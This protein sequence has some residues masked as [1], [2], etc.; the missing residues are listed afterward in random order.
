MGPKKSQKVPL[1]ELLQSNILISPSG[2]ACIADFGQATTK[3]SKPIVM[4]VNTTRGSSGTMKWQAP[5]LFP[6]LLDLD[7]DGIGQPNTQATDIYAFAMVCYEVRQI[8]IG[9]CITALIITMP[10]VFRQI[11]LP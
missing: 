11:S 8:C 7:L 10:D 4:T 9:H 3:D 5:E 2:R 6:E 1:T